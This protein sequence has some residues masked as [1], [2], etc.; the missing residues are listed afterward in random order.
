MYNILTCE[1]VE[2]VEFGLKY[3][4]KLGDKHGWLCSSREKS[5]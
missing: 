2:V 3:N 1:N 5:A 4:F